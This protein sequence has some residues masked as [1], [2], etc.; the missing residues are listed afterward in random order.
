MPLPSSRH[1]VKSAPTLPRALANQVRPRARPAHRTRPLVLLIDDDRAVLES[2][3]RVFAQD[4][5]H[6]TTANSGEQALGLLET[7]QPDLVVTDLCMGAV[8][9]WDLVFHHHLHEAGLPF[10]VI[11]ALS[12]RDAGG[13]EKIAAGFFQ[14]PLSLEAL[15]AVIHARLAASESSA[16]ENEKPKST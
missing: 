8:S 11:T 10:I 13:V 4:G 16:P 2:L 12:L 5:L 15:L 7:L 3:R 9:G 1:Q 14:K 6:V